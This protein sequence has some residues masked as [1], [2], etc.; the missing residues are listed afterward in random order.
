ME[1]G[2]SSDQDY[3]RYSDRSRKRTVFFTE[4]EPGT[5][6]DEVVKSGRK[7]SRGEDP[8]ASGARDSLPEPWQY[9]FYSKKGKGKAEVVKSKSKSVSSTH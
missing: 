4:T 9:N 8:T 6:L 3:R 7:R 5:E 1:C 2:D